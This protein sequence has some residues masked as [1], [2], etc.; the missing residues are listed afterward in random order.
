MQSVERKRNKSD[1]QNLSQLIQSLLLL[2]VS[3]VNDE[4]F[5]SS[6]SKHL[7]EKCCTFF[8]SIKKAEGKKYRDIL[9]GNIV[10]RHGLKVSIFVHLN[11]KYEV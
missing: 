6:I 7:R 5:Y 1:F 4:V 9:C 2:P 11:A 3:V 8:Y 10:S